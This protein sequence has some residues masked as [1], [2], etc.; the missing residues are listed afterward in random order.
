MALVTKL[1]LDWR[2][3]EKS[4]LAD[5]L[6][7]LKLGTREN[8]VEFLVNTKATYLVLNQREKNLLQ[9]WEILADKKKHS[10]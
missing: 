5:P 4:T 1:K 2:R 6:V 10:F 7:K 3:P 8:E 9:L